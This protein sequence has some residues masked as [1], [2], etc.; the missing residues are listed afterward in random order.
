MNDSKIIL[1]MMRNSER[2]D[3]KLCPSKWN[4]RWNLNLVPKMPRMGALWFGTGWHI[5]WA[6]HYTPPP[7]TE[8]N[9]K[10]GFIRGRDP[11]ETWDEFSKN[12]YEKI[13]TSDYFDEDAEQTFEDAQKL[14][15]IMI[16]G[17]L[18]LWQSDPG[19]EVLTPEQRFSARIPYTREQLARREV[20]Q[21][22]YGMPDGKHAVRMVGTFDMP[23]RDHSDGR[24]RIKVLDW[25][26]TSRREN[27]KQLNKDD[28]TGTYV[29]VS[30][31]FLRKAG[32]IKPD[33]SVE[34]MI[35]S[36]ARK[37]KPMENVDENGT[38]R[39]KPLKKHFHEEFTRLGIQFSPKDTIADLEFIANGAKIKVWGDPSKN[40]GAPLFWREAVRRNRFNTARQL[41]RIAEEAEHMAAIRAGVLPVL[42]TPG[43]HCNWCEFSDLCD[44]HEDGGDVEQYIHDIYNQ[45][46]PYADHRT[47]AV[48]SKTSVHNKKET[49]VQ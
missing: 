29:G 34:G 7:G 27:L 38:V 39:N 21:Q 13:R 47:G 4:W 42:K 14:G 35:F 49:G 10:R 20:L 48:N 5:V 2:Q 28:Q 36:F 12:S 11:H 18:K 45:D 37:A 41:G 43:D 9:P 15:H 25:K 44:I 30:T 8:N 32:L 46:D 19:F 1:P 3:F 24:G 33:E 22:L 16:D 26:T 17:Q 40:Q 23:I 6:E 31:M